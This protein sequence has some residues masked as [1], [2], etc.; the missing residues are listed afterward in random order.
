MRSSPKTR[1]ALFLAAIIVSYLIGAATSRL[2]DAVPRRLSPYHNLGIFTRVLTHIE[3][4]YVEEVDQD[5][6][7][8]GAIRGLVGTL[9]PHS[10]FMDPEEFRLLQSDTTGRFGGIGIEIDMRDGMPTVVAPLDG[11]PAAEAGIR[12]GDQITEIDGRNTADMTI[13]DAVRVMR[14]Q[15][16][17]R[18]RLKLR[19]AGVEAPIELELVRAIIRVESVEARSLER[20]IAYVRIKAFQERTAEHLR[21]ELDRLT[22]DGGGSLRGL[23]LDLRNDP[24]GLLDQ[25]VLVS[26]EFLAEGVIVSTR[27]QGGALLDEER[28][29]ARGTRDGFPMVVLVNEYSASAS[30]IV[31]GALQDHGRAV[32]I[33]KRT[34]GKGSVQ[35]IIDLP[36]GSGLKLT[37]A[38]YYTP[39][40]RSIQ[41]EGIRPDIE[42][43]ELPAPAAGAAPPPP[44]S[45]VRESDLEQHLSNDSARRVTESPPSP[46]ENDF[47]LQVGY[48]HLR[49]LIMMAERRRRSSG[50]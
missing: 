35:N 41:A 29:H 13:D 26:D 32:V 27:G 17:S 20:G 44:S 5:R 11:T 1:T 42:V 9:D 37:I 4:S 33:G 30:E 45:P 8:Y 43:P 2:A 38:R 7:V 39:S 46:V 47:Q 31:A 16:G 15:P 23:V 12:S 18:V 6:L 25:A 3:S 19:R 50:S 14:G 21:R 34:F 10:S 36:D 48:H 40:G 28:A 22:S 24:G 49:S